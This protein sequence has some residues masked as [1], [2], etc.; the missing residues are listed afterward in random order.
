ME[1]AV[2]EHFPSR[3]LQNDDNNDDDFLNLDDNEGENAGDLS[4]RSADWQEVLGGLGGKEEDDDDEGQKCRRELKNV[5]DLIQ[6][7]QQSLVVEESLY[8]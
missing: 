8:L 2:N 4:P 3:N 5:F 7:M 1:N 6:V